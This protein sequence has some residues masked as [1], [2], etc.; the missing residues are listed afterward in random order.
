MSFEAKDA[1]DSRK[2]FDDNQPENKIAMHRVEDAGGYFQ[3]I[4]AIYSKTAKSRSMDMSSLVKHFC[5]PL[6]QALPRRFSYN[7]S[8]CVGFGR[9]TEHE[10]AGSWFKWL[11]LRSLRMNRSRN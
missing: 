10:L 1:Q 2:F 9:N 8:L 3:T 4:S 11:A 5:S 7:K 6:V